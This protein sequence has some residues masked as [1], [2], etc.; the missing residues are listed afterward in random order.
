MKDKIINKIFK[1]IILP[2]LVGLSLFVAG[3][4]FVL[5]AIW[6]YDLNFMQADI[7]LDEGGVW[8]R[9]VIKCWRPGECEDAGGFW[10]AAESRCVSK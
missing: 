4:Y 5:F 3:Y 10:F 6:D 2:A 9:E 1:I 8:D 7:C